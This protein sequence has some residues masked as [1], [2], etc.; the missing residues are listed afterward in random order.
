MPV[1]LALASLIIDK[2]AIEKKYK[3]G[4]H[5]FRLDYFSQQSEASQ[6]DDEIFMIARMNYDDYDLDELVKMGLEY[7]KETKYSNDFVIHQRY[8]GYLWQVDWIEDNKF[9]AWHINAKDEL[10]NKAKKFGEITLN[11]L[12][13]I[14]ANDQ[15]LIIPLPNSNNNTHPIALLLNLTNDLSL[16][17]FKDK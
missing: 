12:E 13:K 5:Q 1:Y 2:N 8:H 9:Y 14:Y 15:E 7:N 16:G 11:E 17:G 10:K 4:I 6:E 3:G